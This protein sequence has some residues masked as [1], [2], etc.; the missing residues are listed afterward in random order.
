[1]AATAGTILKFALCAIAVALAGCVG[2]GLRPDAAAL[3]QVKQVQ[4]V[5]METLPLSVDAAYSA[6]ANASII[7]FLPRYT[8]GAARTVGVLSGVAIL[9]ELP[10]LSKRRLDLP[11]D[12]QN[13]IR[14]AETW[15]PTVELA[16]EAQRLISA[17]GTPNSLA[18]GTRPI[19]GIAERGRTV[20]ME[21][22]LAPI[23][24]WYG[25]DAPTTGYAATAG[26][27]VVELGI[28][29]YEIFDR[30]LL[31]QVHLRLIDPASGRLL[32]RARASS[33]TELPAMDAL[34]T[35]DARPFKDAVIRAGAPLLATCLQELGLMRP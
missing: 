12:V 34:F 30:K 16:R 5:P 14:P 20:L 35:N 21:N 33:F 22:W 10:E 29:N 18:A 15:E 31:L 26:G 2:P 17:A 32:G 25:S 9:L 8:I 24:A 19:P 27:A 6:T 11:E 1:M 13:R 3:A 28:S 7:P 4:I 23:R